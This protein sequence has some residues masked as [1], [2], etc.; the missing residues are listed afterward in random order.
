MSRQVVAAAVEGK[1]RPTFA[2]RGPS[3]IPVLNSFQPRQ[4]VEPQLGWK[5]A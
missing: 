1:I 5:V 2:E 3:T 4:P